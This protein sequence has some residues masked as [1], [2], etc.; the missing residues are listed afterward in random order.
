MNN[1]FEMSPSQVKKAV[2]TCMKARLV[3]LLVS[4]PGLGK[5]SIVKQIAEEYG[6][7]LIDCRLSSMEP[8]DLNGL[9]WMNQGKAEFHP[10]DVFP[11]EGTPVPKG[12]EGWILFLDEF[13]SASRAIQAAAYRVVLDREIGQHKLHDKCFVVAAGNKM[14]DNAIVNRL[15]TAMLSRVV[16]LN[17]T[18]NFDDWKYD[19]AVPNKVDERVIA[20][21]SMF[22][23]KLMEFDPEKEDQTFAS[24]RTWEFVSKL[25]KA[26]DKPLDEE[27]IPLLGGAVTVEHASAF[28]QFCKVFDKLID[29]KKIEANPNIEPPMDTPALW[30]TITHLTN[31]VTPKNIGKVS[32]FLKKCPATFQIVFFRSVVLTCPAIRMTPEFGQLTAEL[33]A[34]CFGD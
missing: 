11:I 14:T 31:T 9:P 21:L 25:L 20:Y 27:A 23:T 24:P 16:H 7:K 28:V 22:P 34:Y 30:A 26:Y 13:N 33:G 15:S 6:L 5:S 18:V 32:T 29:I 2:E 4:S 10:F 8:T 12:Y 19:F 1:I 3:P 17:M